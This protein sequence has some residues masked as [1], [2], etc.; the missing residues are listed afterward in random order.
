MEEF[1]RQASEYRRCTRLNTSTY[2][3]YIYKGIKIVNENEGGIK[4]YTSHFGDIYREI[5]KEDYAFFLSFGFRSGVYMLCLR[6]YNNI[7]NVIKTK[8]KNEINSRNN[9]RHY[10]ALREQREH[11]MNK[12]ALVIKLKK[13]TNECE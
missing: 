9:Q 3:S 10:N 8:V 12:Y 7:L 13:E 1:W 4:I 11:Y 2:S 5:S 6:N